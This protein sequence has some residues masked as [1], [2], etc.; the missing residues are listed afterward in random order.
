VDLGFENLKL[1]FCIFD[2]ATQL[3]AFM[4]LILKTDSESSIAKIVALAKTLNVSVEQRESVIKTK[5]EK[6]QLVN[7]ILDFNA[8][9]DSSFGDAA[10]WQRNERDDHNL[11][12]SK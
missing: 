6:E 3:D 8:K 10:E 4:E 9:G 11:P 7:R 5:K 12:F 1:K 2:F